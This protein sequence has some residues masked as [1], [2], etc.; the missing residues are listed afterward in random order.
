MVRSNVCTFFSVFFWLKICRQ[1]IKTLKIID[2]N[3]ICSQLRFGLY[4]QCTHKCSLN[5]QITNPRNFGTI[6]N[7]TDSN[8]RRCVMMIHE[9]NNTRK[10][11]IAAV[12]LKIISH[13]YLFL[14]R[15]LFSGS[16]IA[17]FAYRN[18][19]WRIHVLCYLLWR[20]FISDKTK[21]KR[22]GF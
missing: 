12:W 6:T 17:Q 22:V 9:F 2:V 21:S 8:R 13:R 16:P 1:S 7:P 20:N 14:T 18:L 10:I 15:S 19:F 4:A 5:K 3:P 11:H